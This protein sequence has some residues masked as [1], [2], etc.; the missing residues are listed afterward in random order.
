[1]RGYLSPG[2]E[3]QL[4][5]RQHGIALAFPLARAFAV[6]GLGTAL[7]LYGT[8]VH[9]LF[10]PLGAGLLGAAAVLALGA[11][12]RWD[13]TELVLTSEKLFAAAP[14]PFGSPVS[15]RSRSS[16]ASSVACSGTGRSS[17]GSSRSHMSPVRA[18]SAGSFAKAPNELL[19][20]ACEVTTF[21]IV[22]GT[23]RPREDQFTQ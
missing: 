2:E 11:V 8:R 13:R 3:V 22:T 15:V 9:W 14:Q 12:W 17:R 1:M 20:A 21:G 7:I 23:W 6:A 4:E 18:T 5:A 19:A 16:R 10:A